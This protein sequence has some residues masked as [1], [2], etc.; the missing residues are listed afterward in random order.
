MLEPAV[1]A[2][3]KYVIEMTNKSIAEKDKIALAKKLTSS[4]SARRN[5]GEF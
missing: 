2:L 3:Y 1:L 5:L 4:T